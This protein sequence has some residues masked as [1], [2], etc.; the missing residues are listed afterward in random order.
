MIPRRKR[1]PNSAALSQGRKFVND[2]N[3][4]GDHALGYLATIAAKRG[5][6]QKEL[7]LRPKAVASCQ[8]THPVNSVHHR[9]PINSMVQVRFRHAEQ[10]MAEG[11]SS[12]A[13]SLLLEMRTM[14]RKPI[15]NSRAL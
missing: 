8:R 13:K 14:R 1:L 9:G 6:F 10:A 2:R 4:R 11:D 3:P 12:K 5:D 7:E 15:R